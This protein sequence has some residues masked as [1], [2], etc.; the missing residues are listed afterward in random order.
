MMYFQPERSPQSHALNELS[1]EYMMFFQ[2]KNQPELLYHC[3]ILTQ[4]IYTSVPEQN[5]PAQDTSVNESVNNESVNESANESANKESGQASVSSPTVAAVPV[6]ESAAVTDGDENTKVY[7]SE[8]GT[9]YHLDPNCSGM[10]NPAQITLK[11]AKEMGLTPCKK[12]FH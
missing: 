11:Q 9:K 2:P 3:I 7:V 4:Q 1:H 10:N 12:C 8:T 6:Q 5:Q